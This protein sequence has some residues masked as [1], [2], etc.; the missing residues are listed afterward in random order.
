[1]VVNEPSTDESYCGLYFNHNYY[2]NNNGLDQSN[3]A[4]TAFIDSVKAQL[5]MGRSSIRININASASYVPTRS[6]KNNANLAKIRAQ[7]VEDYLRENLKEY[8]IA[9]KVEIHI[10]SAKVQGPIYSRSDLRNLEKYAPYQFVSLQTEA[11]NC[12]S[13]TKY[14]SMDKKLEALNVVIPTKQIE[15]EKKEVQTKT[16][17]N[18]HVIVYTYNDRQFA[19]EVIVSNRYKNNPQAQIIEDE[20]GNFLISIANFKTEQEAK[21]FIANY[22]YEEKTNAYIYQKK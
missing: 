4:L 2:Y 6:Y 18:Y 8:I 19:E 17:L 14:E 22:K 10:E 5:E 20:R 16:R 15:V 7:K 1:L 21:N 12:E 11:I 3:T 9:R 13:T